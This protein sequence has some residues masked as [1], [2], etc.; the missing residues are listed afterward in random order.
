M[1]KL[2]ALC[3]LIILIFQSQAQT[4]KT[5]KDIKSGKIVKTAS[6]T[7]TPPTEAL[8]QTIKFV[9]KGSEKS[10]YIETL[11]KV[12]DEDL[13]N[14]YQYEGITVMFSFEDK[15]SFTLPIEKNL[16]SFKDLPN[17]GHF[18]SIGLKI[19]D[20]QLNYFL[21]YSLLQ[22]TVLATPQNG[23]VLRQPENE[24]ANQLK[25]CAAYVLVP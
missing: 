3:A 13:K 10:I 19:T 16:S 12:Y 9:S 22:I 25:N 23:V 7:L 15:K 4:L 18:V 11:I 24:M 1:K 8:K 14:T 21:K 2:L 17:K 6:L 20:E 5:F